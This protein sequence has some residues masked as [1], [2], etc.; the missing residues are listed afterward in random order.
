MPPLQS[1]NGRSF[2]MRLLKIQRQ[3]KIRQLRASLAD[4]MTV[5]CVAKNKSF[6]DYR[7]TMQVVVSC[8]IAKKGTVAMLVM[9]SRS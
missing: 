7:V 4:K 9:E 3:H 5:A 6:S 1:E 2:P 8:K